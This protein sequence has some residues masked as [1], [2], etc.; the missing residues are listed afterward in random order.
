MVRVCRKKYIWTVPS[1]G[2][3]HPKKST[4][5]LGKQAGVGEMWEKKKQK[6][7]VCHFPVTRDQKGL[8]SWVCW[9]QR[10]VSVGLALLV[11]CWRGPNT[12]NSCSGA[13]WEAPGE[14]SCPQCLGH[15]APM[16]GK[17][18][19]ES[20]SPPWTRLYIDSHCHPECVSLF[21]CAASGENNQI[22][23]L[24]QKPKAIHCGME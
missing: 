10:H 5:S 23:L 20:W 9:V 3:I 1:S 16:E 13:L 14:T 21:G 24:G 2:Q 22:H 18:L 8:V 4:A 19:P 17:Y 6:P 15:G 7:H 11:W 12:N